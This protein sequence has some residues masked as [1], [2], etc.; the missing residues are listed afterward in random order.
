MS[1]ATWAVA[2]GGDWNTAADWN[3]GIVPDGN[4]AV[5]VMPG[6]ASSGYT[7]SI[8]VGESHI[9]NAIT[10]GDLV[11]GHVGATLEVAG[12]LSFAGAGA[13]MATLLG[14]LQIDATGA[15]DGAGSIG[16]IQAGAFSF[17]ND[18]TVIGDA[19][20][21]SLL[22]ILTGFTNNG[23][24][25]ADNGLVGIEGS[26]GVA[27]LSG[28]TLAGGTWIAQGPS[29]GTFNQ[30]EI[31]FN[32]DAVIA[33][34]AANIVLDG[35][36][37]DIQG[38][39]GGTFR[40]I[41]QQL[42][43]I[44]AGGTL[45]LLN[46]RGFA[47]TNAI[48]DAG[49]LILQGGTLTT[50]GLTIGSTGS[51]MGSG[52]IAGG[53]TTQGAII[54]NSGVLDIQNA[55]TGSGLFGTTAGA[56]L[57]LNGANAGNLNNQGT[58]YNASGL[59]DI[60]GALAGNGS[61]IVQHGATIEI[62]TATNQSVTFSG[63]NATLELDNFSGYLGTLVG[64][65]KGD[66]VVL[67]GT[68]ATSAFVAG[69]SL[70][71]KN[72][73]ATVDTIALAG[74][75]A[76]GASFTVANTGSS[77]VV[78]NTGG[79][80]MQQNFQ[81][82]ILPVN[83]TAGLGASEDALIANDLSAAALDW[84]QY[85]TGHAPLRIQ[86]NILSGTSGSELAHAGATT[87]VSNGTTQDGRLLDTPS[88]LIAL[89]TG[90]YVQGF[91]SDIDVTFLAGNL[92][93]IY[94]NPSPTPM[95]SGTVPAG[96]FDLVTVFRH[97]L[98]HGFGF[99]GLTTSSGSIDGQ[100]TLFDHFIQN[101]GGTVVFTGAHAEAEYGVL[102]GTGTATP[103]PLTDLFGNG[104]DFAHFANSTLDVNATDLMSGL[105][106]PPATQRDISAMDLAV[107]Q[108]VGAPVTAAPGVVCFAR[109]TR[110][111]TPAGDVAVEELAPGRLVWTASGGQA[112]IVWIG[113]RRIDCTRHP[114]P[115]LAW[116]VRIRAHAFGEALPRRDLWVSPQHAL[117]LHGV[118]IPAR[119]LIDGDCVAQVPV[120]EVE[121]WHI[122]LPRHDVVL[123]EG[124]PAESYLDCGD[125][126][127]LDDG[128]VIALHPDFASQVWESR[129]CAP[130]KVAGPEVEAVRSGLRRFAGDRS[131]A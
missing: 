111:A 96:Q 72:G 123:A 85:L 55:V 47:T 2:T 131:A 81:F 34:D 12:T 17:T 128:A 115:R 98:A 125:R 106:L 107:L 9:V 18:G 53:V 80:P 101:V 120:A 24:V 75:Y 82:S 54:A 39:S 108:D 121:Y 45:Q 1:S 66:A 87:N 65:A 73:G 119:C 20:T 77:V 68:S 63:S 11:G 51:L 42:Q 91:T 5:A 61:L 13:G 3:T 38:F 23:T 19:G 26:A 41:E 27:N 116:P 90:N 33:V 105:G 62:A 99:G 117:Y 93:S 28:S 76:P 130:L 94:V 43:T 57:I 49:R 64:F 10:L 127:F 95:S 35:G 114:R 16:T 83:D 30:I 113:R 36:A 14:A 58:L 32:F 79:A 89:N 74:S 110:I 50:G 100:E 84:A 109:G 6:A 4:T 129:A 86:L 22:G 124:L 7:V 70:V 40:P 103:V 92:G 126:M 48:T 78:T 97:E 118:L 60:A 44:A 15:L 102:L 56:T 122:E 59:L 52:V 71:V 69:S 37:S 67:M 31:G 29:A 104:E 112:P 46:D 8:G 25:L 21:S 88:S